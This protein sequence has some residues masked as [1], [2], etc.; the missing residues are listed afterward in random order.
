MH[1]GASASA[2]NGNGNG[3]GGEPYVPKYNNGPVKN[4]INKKRPSGKVPNPSK[5]RR[6]P[7]GAHPG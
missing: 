2:N 4:N 5:R 3:T 7:D 6:D 1:G